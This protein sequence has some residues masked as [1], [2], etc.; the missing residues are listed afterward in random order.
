MQVSKNSTTDKL[1]ADILL[2]GLVIQTLSFAFFMLLV[3]H[4]WRSIL[5]DSIQPRQEPWGPILWILM[6]S[7]TAY[8]VHV[9]S[10]I[11]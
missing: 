4:T 8:M 9:R 2:A 1:G 11:C 3:V 7:S 10:H 6:F 5:K